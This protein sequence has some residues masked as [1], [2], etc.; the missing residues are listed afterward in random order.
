MGSKH[1]DTVFLMT[2]GKLREDGVERVSQANLI[3]NGSIE[4]MTW[5]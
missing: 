1:S 3:P 5:H 4:L 2:M